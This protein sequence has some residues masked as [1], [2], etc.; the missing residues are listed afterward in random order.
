MIAIC[1]TCHQIYRRIHL[2]PAVLAKRPLLKAN[3][4]RSLV[5]A[6]LSTNLSEN[7]LLFVYIG[8]LF[9]LLKSYKT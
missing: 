3:L 1:A 4:V 7:T 5:A 9:V 6:A 8:M 2:S